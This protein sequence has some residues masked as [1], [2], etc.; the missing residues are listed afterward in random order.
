MS[1]QETGNCCA[2]IVTYNP[3][4]DVLLKLAGQL[5]RETDFIVVDNASA[6]VDDFAEALTGLDRCRALLRR[7]QNEGLAKG[8]NLGLAWIIDQGYDLALMFDQDSSLLD[9]FVAS[10]LM[11]R[12]E[13]RSL[14]VKLAA[15]GPRI[16]EPE[17][18]RR[19]AFKLFDRLWRRSEQRVSGSESLY[20]SHFLITSG[21]LLEL[22]NLSKIG[23]MRADYFIDNV[24]LEW[25]F[26]A[27][28]RGFA[29]FGS[30]RAQLLHRIGEPSADP[31]VRAGLVVHHSPLRAYYSSRNRRHLW[32]SDYAPRGWKWRDRIRFLL[33]STWL[34]LSSARRREYWREIR[35]GLADAETLGEAGNVR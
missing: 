4:R 17:S 1:P 21:C 16:V 20:H 32:H 2:L 13:A 30:D 7:E 25:C 11:A 6:N 34:L 22:E 8:L 14:D 23:L 5:A 26:R 12:D 35:R 29:L 18:G 24:D 15:I 31:L 19:Q 33:K 28:A 10:M 9:D 3:D 27:L